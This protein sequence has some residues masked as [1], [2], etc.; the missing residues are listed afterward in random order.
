MSLN[1]LLKIAECFHVSTDYLIKGVDKYEKGDTRE[2]ISLINRCSG[3][4]ISVIEDVT[5]V[6]LPHI[7]KQK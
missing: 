1:T 3:E 6:I 4:E 5:K 7:K 2:I